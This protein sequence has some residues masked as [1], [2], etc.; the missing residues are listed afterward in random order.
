MKKY[1]LYLDDNTIAR[2]KKLKKETGTP[3]SWHIREAVNLYLGNAKNGKTKN[4]RDQ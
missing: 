2:L 3:V 1:T 4:A